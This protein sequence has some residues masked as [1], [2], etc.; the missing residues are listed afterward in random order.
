M[1]QVLEVLLLEVQDAPPLKQFL[2]QLQV[3]LLKTALTDKEFFYRENHPAR[4]LLDQLAQPGI[5]IHPLSDPTE[6]YYQTIAHL[7]ERLQQDRNLQSSAYTAAVAD[8]HALLMD[9]ERRTKKALKAPIA[10]AL[11]EEKM[12]QAQQSAENDIAARI[13]TGEVAGFIEIFLETQ[14]VRVLTL[15][16]SV[17]KR[18]PKALANA[19]K[20]MDD[21]IWSVK[22]K[23]SA[24]ECSDLISRLPS[25]LSSINAWLDAVKWDGTER[26]SFFSTLVERHAAIVQR[27]GELSPRHQIH[28][29][30]NVAQKA[31]ERRLSR[32]ARELDAPRIDE[33]DHLVDSLEVGR[34][35]EFVSPSKQVTPLRLVWLSPLR[36]RFIFCNRQSDAPFLMTADALA[37]ALREQGAT[38]TPQGSMSTRALILALDKLGA[39]S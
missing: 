27:P 25:M 11:H 8:L 18:K 37:R 6:P 39:G 17:A 10:A 22:P 38:L 14:W 24:E 35:I 15:T 32:R 5:G 9:Q 26:V 30:V 33:F 34:W 3:P 4:Q 28:I 36:K 7:V 2:A 21:L 19:L 23:I 12:W 20:T 1:A 29:A 16:H 31:S 13:E